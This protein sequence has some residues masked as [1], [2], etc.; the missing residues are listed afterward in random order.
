MIVEVANS[1]ELN[2]VLVV[3][4]D[5]AAAV[6]VADTLW[7]LGRDRDEQGRVIPGAKVKKT[8]NLVEMGLTWHEG[9]SETKEFGDVVREIRSV[10]PTL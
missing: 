5:I 6:S 7:L 3:T 4:H 1:D 9:L 2:T 8:Y 10:F